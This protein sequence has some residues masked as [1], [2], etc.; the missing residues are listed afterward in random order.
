MIS[1]TLSSTVEGYTAYVNSNITRLAY[2]RDA[3]SLSLSLKLENSSICP[4]QTTGAQVSNKMCSQ[5]FEVRTYLA[6]IQKI[7]AI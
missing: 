5:I 6:A 3:L 2:W 4:N 7:K 1:R